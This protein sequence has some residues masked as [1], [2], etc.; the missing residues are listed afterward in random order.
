MTL[1]LDGQPAP[2]GRVLLGPGTPYGGGPVAPAALRSPEWPLA[3]PAPVPSFLRLWVRQGATV[4]RRPPDPET[5][6]RL[7]AL[8]YI[9]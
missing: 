9:Q 6:K 7:R 4:K 1:S 8:G 2:P 5:E 3:S